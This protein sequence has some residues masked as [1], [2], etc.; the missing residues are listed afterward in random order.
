MMGK[1]LRGNGCEGKLAFVIF[2]TVMFELL[3]LSELCP[4]KTSGSLRVN[5]SGS[6][7]V[8]LFA[9]E[10]KRWRIR[11][12]HFKGFKPDPMRLL[13]KAMSSPPKSPD[14]AAAGLEFAASKTESRCSLT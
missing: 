13:H 5:D 11:C 6:S 7:I 12:L 4:R 1:G 2:S 8:R 14:K 10:Q 9:T 3:R